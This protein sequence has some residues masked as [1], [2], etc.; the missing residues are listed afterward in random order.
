VNVTDLLP[1][2]CL[3]PKIRCPRQ[4]DRINCLRMPLQQMRLHHLLDPLWVHLDLQVLVYLG[5]LLHQYHHQVDYH[6]HC[7]LVLLGL[8][9]CP[10]FLLHP[11]LAM[12]ALVVGPQECVLRCHLHPDSVEAIILEDH[13]ECV[14]LVVL[15]LVGCHLLLA[16]TVAHHVIMVHLDITEGHMDPQDIMEVR[17][18]PHMEDRNMEDLLM[19]GGDHLHLDGAHHVLQCTMEVLMV[20]LE[21]LHVPTWV[22]V[23]LMEVLVSLQDLPIIRETDIKSNFVSLKFCTLSI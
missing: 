17:M 18:G 1:R 11:H 12:V 4:T 21:V 8:I 19:A 2:D 23:V 7:L 5:C 13:L 9:L 14:C 15:H 10:T 3:Q 22:L 16:I 20:V 6:H